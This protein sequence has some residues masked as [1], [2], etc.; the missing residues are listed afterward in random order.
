MLNLTAH[1]NAISRIA[2]L[3]AD[4][5]RR[6]ADDAEAQLSEDLCSTCPF[7]SQ[8]EPPVMGPRFAELSKETFDALYGADAMART[9]RIENTDIGCEPG[10]ASRIVACAP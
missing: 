8:A 5:L 7:C 9:A 4:E 6:C 3:D 10:Y 2:A 1:F